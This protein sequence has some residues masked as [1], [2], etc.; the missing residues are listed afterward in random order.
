M[1]YNTIMTTQTK[2]AYQALLLVGVPIVAYLISRVSFANRDVPS[3]LWVMIYSLIAMVY[4]AI[5]LALDY[6]RTR[7]GKLNFIR[8]W[9]RGGIYTSIVLFFLLIVENI[10]LA[11]GF[12]GFNNDFGLT[13]PQTIYYNSFYTIR[14]YPA[15]F[16]SENS[17]V[18]S[19]SLDDCSLAVEQI[20]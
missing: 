17:F 4:F 3:D 7:T 15:D 5:V 1:I 10:Y 2:L 12:I 16:L 18:D 20:Y 19:Y 6:Y 9:L 8:R 13:L 11:G 14:A